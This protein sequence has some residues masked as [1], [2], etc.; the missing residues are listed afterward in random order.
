MSQARTNPVRQTAILRAKIRA[1]ERRYG[2][3]FTSRPSL[4]W[5][6]RYKM[7]RHVTIACRARPKIEANLLKSNTI[8]TPPQLGERI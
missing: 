4:A 1:A 7:H 2:R 8:S 3:E 5:R 6:L